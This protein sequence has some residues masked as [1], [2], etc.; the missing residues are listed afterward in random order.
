MKP[1]SLPPHIPAGP[2]IHVRPEPPGQYTAQLV[3]L[4]EL[5]ATAGTQEAAIEQVRTVLATWLTSGTLVPANAPP[6]T[7]WIKLPPRIDPNDPL[8]REFLEEL[9]RARQ[10]DLER[11]LRE[12]E[13]EDNA[14]PSPSSTPTT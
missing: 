8:E 6:Q 9:A 10:Q 2:L 1:D 14:C 13:M 7:S 12:Y 5:C 11:T 4:P 3:G